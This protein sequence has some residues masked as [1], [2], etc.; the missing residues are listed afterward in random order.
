MDIRKLT[1]FIYDNNIKLLPF[2]I[3]DE[4]Y[5][6]ICNELLR[7]QYKYDSAFFIENCCTI[8]G[9]PIKLNSLQKEICRRLDEKINSSQQLIEITNNMQ[10]FIE[11]CLTPLYQFQWLK[12]IPIDFQLQQNIMFMVAYFDKRLF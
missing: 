8:N 2:T 11:E 4:Q 3:N 9:K 5:E 12:T 6:T 1:R 7:Y 10:Q